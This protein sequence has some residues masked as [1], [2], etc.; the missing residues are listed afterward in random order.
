MW[1]RKKDR[2]G[3]EGQGEVR[4]DPQARAA[5]PGAVDQRRVTELV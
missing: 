2:D 3:Q 5:Q 4:V 1:Q